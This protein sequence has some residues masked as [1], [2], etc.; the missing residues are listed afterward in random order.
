MISCILP[1][2]NNEETVEHVLST[3]L[4]S[5]F[6]DEVIVVNDASTDNS[7][8]I[9][10]KFNSKIKLITNSINLGKGGAFVEGLKVAKGNLILTCDADHR[11]FR[12]DHIENII[13]E[14]LKG[15][16]DMVL[17]AREG[18]KGWGAL[19]API[20]GE[21]IFKKKVIEKYIDL[22]KSSRF[23]MEQIINYAHK[24]KK[25][26]ILVS[27]DIGHILKFRRKNFPRWILDYLVQISQMI[28]TSNELRKF[29]SFN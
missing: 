28:R 19:M 26:K 2:Y 9:L 11:K 23:G 25:T 4:N 13:K 18:D 7:C 10:A 22:I 15:E 16:H 20:T 1:V 8:K 6:I 29:K 27:K 5:H 17:G 24:G 21:R 12:L 14:Y 3:L